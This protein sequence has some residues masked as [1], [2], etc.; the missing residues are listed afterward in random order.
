VQAA[1]AG[2][3]KHAAASLSGFAPSVA[4][5]LDLEEYD[6]EELE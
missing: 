5:D 1:L 2:K 3:L 4:Q 6:N